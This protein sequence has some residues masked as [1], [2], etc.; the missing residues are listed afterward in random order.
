[1]RNDYIMKTTECNMSRT[2][3]QHR[4]TTIATSKSNTSAAASIASGAASAPRDPAPEPRRG[5]RPTPSAPHARHRWGHH[6]RTVGMLRS[7]SSSRGRGG[8][9]GR[10]EQIALA[11]GLDRPSPSPLTISTNRRRPH[12]A[13]PQH[14]TR[15]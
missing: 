11:A 10:D 7:P 14:P 8:R 2:L 15:R 12:V 6:R 13:E 5:G 3:L 9:A 1:M 4:Y